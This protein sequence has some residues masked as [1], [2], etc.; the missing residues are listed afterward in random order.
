MV[1]VVVVVVVVVLTVAIFS[2][3]SGGGGTVQLHKQMYDSSS[4]SAITGKHNNQN[5]ISCVNT[6][7]YM[8]FCVHR[9]F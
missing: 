4:G 6:G 3:S 8:F 9:G 7:E 1:V 2:G 5:Q